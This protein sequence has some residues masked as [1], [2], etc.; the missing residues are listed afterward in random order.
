MA[1][2]SSFAQNLFTKEPKCTKSVNKTDM[3]RIKEILS[4]SESSSI[5]LE[6]NK[7]LSK[8]KERMQENVQT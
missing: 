6:L 7:V 2:Q 3:T 8:M 1:F 4:N 5:Y